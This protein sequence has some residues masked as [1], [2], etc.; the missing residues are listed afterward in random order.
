MAPEKLAGQ[1]KYTNRHS[2]Q[3]SGSQCAYLES[4][5]PAINLS[6][7][8]LG[9]FGEILDVFLSKRTLVFLFRVAH[10]PVL[11]THSKSKQDAIDEASEKQ[12]CLLV[13][14]LCAEI[15]FA[16]SSLRC[17]ASAYIRI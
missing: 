16:I 5:V 6:S 4:L 12:S 14:F 8:E 11:S 10:P 2:E 7:R 3:S 9:L 17:S 15:K 1:G 13:V